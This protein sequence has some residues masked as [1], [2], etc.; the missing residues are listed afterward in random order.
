MAISKD[1]KQAIMA[2]LKD[3]VANSQSIV[4]TNFHGL[5]VQ[6]VSE[7][8]GRMVENDVR[9]K[10]AKKTLIKKAFEAGDI[11]GTMPSLD[12]EIA[13]A[14]G[15]DLIAPAREAY[16]FQKDHEDNFMIVGGVFEGRYMDKEE[17]MEIATIPGQKTLYGMFANVINSPIQGFVSALHQIAEAKEA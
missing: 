15:D 7:L 3:A 16:N 10:V 8:R 13:L 11:A 14:Y 12:G 2:E 4:F 6:A 1:K 5:S 9:Y 17:M